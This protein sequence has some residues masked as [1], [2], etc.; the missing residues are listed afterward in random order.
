MYKDIKKKRAASREWY[1]QNKKQSIAASTAW[2]KAH[3]EEYKASKR[4][5]YLKHQEENRTKARKYYQEKRKLVRLN[6]P[7]A[8]AQEQRWALTRIAKLKEFIQQMKLEK[9]GKC[10]RCGYMEQPRILQFHHLR[11]KDANISEMK[12]LKKIRAEA[13]KCVL[14]CPNCHALTHLNV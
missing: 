14:L 1:R 12:S 13:K 9:G 5:S 4:K 3:P 7:K 2:R 10:T 6:N 8:K 11:D